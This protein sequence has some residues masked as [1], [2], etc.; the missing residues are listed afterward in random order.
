[1]KEMQRHEA[2]LSKVASLD[3]EAVLK[4]MCAKEKERKMK[5][6]KDRE[7]ILNAALKLQHEIEL[8]SSDVALL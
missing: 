4:D 3:R 5:T 1:M 8:V 7:C 6:A 2:D